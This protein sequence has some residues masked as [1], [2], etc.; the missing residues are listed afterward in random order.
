MLFAGSDAGKVRTASAAE[1]QLIVEVDTNPEDGIGYKFDLEVDGNNASGND[2][3]DEFDGVSFTLDDDATEVAI[4]CDDDDADIDVTISVDV[5][6]HSELTGITCV[7]SDA[8]VTGGDQST[9]GTPDVEDDAGSIDLTILDEEH[10]TCDFDFD[11]DEDKITPSATATTTVGPAATIVISSSNN[12]L[13]CGATSIVT[14]TVRGGNGQPVAAGTIV[15]IVADKGSVSPASGVT[16]ADGSVFVFYTAPSNTGGEATIT[17][18]SGSAL[19]TTGIDVNCNTAPTQAPPPTAVVGG[20]QP[21]NTGDGGLSGGSGSWH[22][23]GGV[24][25]M[26]SSVIATLAVIRPRA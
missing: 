24:A 2:C 18:A 25:L 15:N 5:P 11:F 4:E 3:E 13:G 26:L 16:T 6:S 20:I 10:I 14:I 21:P 9:I 17:A 12:N 22:T 1:P 19:G 23:Y 8:G 7:V